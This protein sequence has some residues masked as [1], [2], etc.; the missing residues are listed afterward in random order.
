MEYLIRSLRHLVASFQ[1]PIA[2]ETLLKY[3]EYLAQFDESEMGWIAK[4]APLKFDKFPSIK[5]LVD[6]GHEHRRANGAWA[7]D[8]NHLLPDTQPVKFH[9]INSR[10]D[11]LEER[12]ARMRQLRSRPYVLRRYSDKDNWSG[13]SMVQAKVYIAT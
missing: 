4:R 1:Q 10:P 13:D 2:E 8:K 11:T 5:E 12:A 9:W 7:D 3:A 6:M